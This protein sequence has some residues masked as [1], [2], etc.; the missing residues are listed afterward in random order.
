MKTVNTQ[1]A[2]LIL[3]WKQVDTSRPFYMKPGVSAGPSQPCPDFLMSSDAQ[4]LLRK[5]MSR[6]GWSLTVKAN[7]VN[8]KTGDGNTWTA[9][10]QNSE[11]EF[12]ST[13]PDEN[14][15]VCVAALL[16]AGVSLAPSDIDPMNSERES[17]NAE[18]ANNR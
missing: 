8:L 18:F 2:E 5:E 16:A 4:T 17:E 6:R 14:A 9:K 10:F 11:K 1:I 15:A 13:Q 12:E 3:G 7:K